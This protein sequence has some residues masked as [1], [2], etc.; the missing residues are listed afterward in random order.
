MKYPPPLVP[1]FLLFLAA[2]AVGH[3]QEEKEK[4]KEKENKLPEEVEK[5]IRSPQEAFLYS[6]EPPQL[7]R[8]TPDTFHGYQMHG[9]MKLEAGDQKFALET[10]RSAVAS[11]EGVSA[12]C[13][14]P[15]HGLRLVTKTHTYDVV[16][17]YECMA[18]QVFRDDK[19]IAWGGMSGTSDALN[20]LLEDAKV[21]LPHEETRAGRAEI[22]KEKEAREKRLAENAKR[23]LA[24]TPSSLRKFALK[25]TNP[26]EKSL[27][28]SASIEEMHELVKREFPAT[29]KR[30]LALFE[31]YAWD[32][33]LSSGESYEELPRQLLMMES[34]QKVIASAQMD[35]LTQPQLE[36]AA[37]F[38][39]HPLTALS[40][41]NSL[42]AA[43]KKK[44]LEH[45]L[46]STDK[47]EIKRAREVFEE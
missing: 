37:R 24:A 41:S 20:D 30:C 8:T 2:T 38:Y 32:D 25:P 34:E 35:N 27:H 47:N 12:L 44:L 40:Q 31:W 28:P 46:K 26:F 36:G 7:R 22:Q 6:I 1:L 42:P 3:A 45:C 4:K 14:N 39:L 13:F 15:R 19:A 21:P 17:C 10:L 18:F 43:L 9:R 33:T 5:A 23:W 11:W 29:S 16:M